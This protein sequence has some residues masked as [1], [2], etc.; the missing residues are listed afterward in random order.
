[1]AL[2]NIQT[3]RDVKKLRAHLKLLCCDLRTGE[4]LLREGGDPQ[5]QLCPAPVETTEHL[6]SEC[7]ALYPIRERLLPELLNTV[8]E[9]DPFCGILADPQSPHLTQFLLDCT[10]HNLPIGI[11]LS[12]E[13][14]N[15]TLVFK[16]TRDWCFALIN[17]RTKQLNIRKN[18]QQPHRT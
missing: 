4:Q 17:E 7:R 3:T 6:V 18:A 16:V 5:C 12:P 2:H 14:P 1:M 10:S 15:I 13:N 11:R 9:V 8:L